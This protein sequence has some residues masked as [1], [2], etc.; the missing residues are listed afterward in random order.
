MDASMVLRSIEDN[1]PK[2]SLA[3]VHE[4]LEN[5]T[6]EQLRAVASL[7]FDKDPKKAFILG[8]VFGIFGVDRFYS[9]LS[10]GLGFAKLAPC[11][12][13]LLL[14]TTILG[15]QILLFTLY[16]IYIFVIFDAYTVS[17]ALR[18]KNLDLVLSNLPSHTAS[19][20]QE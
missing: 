18:A 5:A 4:R 17:S 12:L 14:Y 1:L 6:P 2:S 10:I 11:A 8:V 19:Q 7:K 15:F 13:I 20:T 3:L 16:C 9:R